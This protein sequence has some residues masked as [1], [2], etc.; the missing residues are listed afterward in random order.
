MIEKNSVDRRVRI[1]NCHDSGPGWSWLEPIYSGSPAVEWRSVSTRRSSL[2]SKLSRLP[3]PHYGRI[4]AALQIAA[5]LRAGQADMLVTHG[6]YVSYYVE[7]LGRR[8]SRSTPHLAFSF[9]FTDFPKGF[10]FH[11]MR[12]A[13]STIDRFVVFST[14]ERQLYSERFEI[15]V[16]RFTFVPWGVSAPIEVP[17]ERKFDH[18]YVAAAGGEARDYRTLCE[19]ARLLPHVRFVIVVRPNNLDGIDVP[20]NVIVHVN[21]PF[22]DTWSI[23]WHA[24]LAL[25]P[26][27]S[28]TSPN[29]L[30]TLVGGMHLGKAQVV[31]DSIGLHDYM[32]D[33][34]NVR[35]VPPNEPIALAEAITELLDDKALRD[36]LAKNGKVFATERCSEQ[37]TIEAFRQLVKE[38]T[39]TT[40]AS[41]APD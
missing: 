12:R 38:M 14:M 15:P 19:A 3:G 32:E 7:A 39:R 9:N 13:F 36:K 20:E 18:P 33:G 16:E 28:Q 29:G 27:R 35:L 17:L 24:E 22:H 25:I 26:L 10:R 21:L 34:E 23:V 41:G 40:R 30:V 31:T 2:V 5:A 11:E 6:P 1:I 8:R 4:G 37:A